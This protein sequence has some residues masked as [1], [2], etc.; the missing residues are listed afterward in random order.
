MRR[1]GYTIIVTPVKSFDRK[2]APL[3]PTNPLFPYPKCPI[4]LASGGVS[5]DPLQV[6]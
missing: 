2:S 4:S 1:G 6:C 3:I 5:Y